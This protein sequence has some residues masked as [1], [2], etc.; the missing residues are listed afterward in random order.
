MKTLAGGM[1]LAVLLVAVARADLPFGGGNS[2]E[3]FARRYPIRP[4][5]AVP[6]VLEASDDVREPRLIIPRAFPP[7]LGRWHAQRYVNE[8]DLDRLFPK[9]TPA[10]HW[11][12]A[13]G[14]P[15]LENV[16]VEVTDAGDAVRL[17]IPR[18]ALPA[19]RAQ[20]KKR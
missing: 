15:V 6:F 18:A 9:R 1:I 11:S 19:L 14:C 4:S 8:I 10:E 3:R 16:Q 20:L 12:V 7:V 2:L 17:V 13:E 5:N